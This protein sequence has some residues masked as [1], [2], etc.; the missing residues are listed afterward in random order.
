MDKSNN[1]WY[2]EKVNLFR[3]LC[4]TKFG[5]YEESHVIKSYKRDEFIYFTDDPAN[6]IYMI[7]KGK[8]KVLNYTENGNEIIKGILATGDIFGEMAVLGEDKRKDFAQAVNKDTYICH[9]NLEEL[10]GL[11]LE[12]KKFALT[13]NKIIGLRIRRL[14]RKLDA[15]VFKDVRTRLIDFIKDLIET[16]GQ[17]FHGGIRI[18][19]FYTHKD[20]ADLIGTSRQT[21]TTI[22]NELKA[23]SLIDFKRKEIFILNPELFE[24]I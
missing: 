13:I 14:E 6:N 9:M 11:M 12:N 17:P 3:I 10:Q 5:K 15:L 7:T 18:N 24:K 20:I 4:P 19:H 21:V 2:F 8:V 22:F 16:S 1:I 23:E